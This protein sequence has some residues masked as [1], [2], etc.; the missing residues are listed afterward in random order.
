MFIS[1]LDGEPLAVAGLW[2]AWKDRDDPEQR[3][4][5]SATIVTRAANETM[6]PVHDRMPVLIPRSRWAEWLDPANDGID[7]LATLFTSPD[8]HSLGLVPVSRDVNNVRNNG[9][10]LIVPTVP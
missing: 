1:R 4:L 2:T 10:E 6:Q 7:E 9:P 5:H 8:D 3:Y